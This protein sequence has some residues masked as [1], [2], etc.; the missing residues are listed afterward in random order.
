[1]IL[2]YLQKNIVAL[3][4]LLFLNLNGINLKNYATFTLLQT[5]K[6]FKLSHVQLYQRGSQ[7]RYLFDIFADI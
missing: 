1:M 7:T 6:Y 2:I 3:K 4:H 5:L